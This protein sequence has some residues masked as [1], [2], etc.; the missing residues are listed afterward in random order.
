M[1]SECAH[2][3]DDDQPVDNKTV[4]KKLETLKER[5]DKEEKRK[6]RPP[7]SLENLL[8]NLDAANSHP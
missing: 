8:A 5:K 7:P 2:S 3:H 6:I 4:A 1:L